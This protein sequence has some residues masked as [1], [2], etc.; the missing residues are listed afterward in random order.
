MFAHGEKKPF[1]V[2]A[3]KDKKLCFFQANRAFEACGDL[4]CFVSVGLQVTFNFLHCSLCYRLLEVRFV[5]FLGFFK[6]L[7]LMSDN[8]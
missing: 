6:V 4:S 8:K 1:S 3:I 7:W 5:F 2:T